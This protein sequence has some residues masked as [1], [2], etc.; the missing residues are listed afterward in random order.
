MQDELITFL[1]S[2]LIWIMFALLVVLWFIDGKIKKEQVVHALLASFIAFTIAEILKRVFNTPRP[3]DVNH[4][5]T[6]VVALPSDP[7]FP[8]VHATVVFALSITIWL[9]DHKVGLIFIILAIL[10]GWARVAANVHYPIDIMGGAII[11][12]IVA[13]LIEKIHLTR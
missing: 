8:S 5:A 4:L 10:V 2:F 11:G 13:L 7:G 3:Y 6:E 1:A 9:H 12:S